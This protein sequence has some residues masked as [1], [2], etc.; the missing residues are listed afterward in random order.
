MF[1]N[2]FYQTVKCCFRLHPA[3]RAKYDKKI[4]FLTDLEKNQVNI[5]KNQKDELLSL[6]KSCQ[7]HS[8]SVI[9][10]SNKMG[11]HGQY[12]KDLADASEKAIN[13][14]SSTEI[15]LQPQIKSWGNLN[16]SLE[17]FD[18][19]IGNINFSVAPSSASIAL[20]CMFNF[21][22]PNY[23]VDFTSPD[24]E[25]EAKTAAKNL[26]C[27]IDKLV[28][29]QDALQLLDEF[30]LS[31]TSV[32]KR[33]PTELLE[34]ACAAFERPVTQGCS[35]ST[36]L[37]P[38]RECIT[39]TIAVLLRRRPQQEPAKSQKSKIVS[40]GNQISYSEVEPWAFVQMA[41]Q[42]G[43]L[44]DKLSSSK[45]ED[46][47][48]GEWKAILREALAFLIGFLRSLDPKKMRQL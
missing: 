1:F 35:A 12:V 2:R 29:K 36:S 39:S 16:I 27:V 11:K 37:I 22:N 13:C 28:E 26:E 23:L 10:R 21:T 3:H 33:S 42:W 41:E 44:L 40:I 34:D 25:A 48:R 19:D 7:I 43:I 24:R 6:I 18:Q 20:S 31:S 45:D 4:A 38:M 14:I 8:H 30:G 5:M 46:V 15:D 9:E 17:R 32:G 47:N